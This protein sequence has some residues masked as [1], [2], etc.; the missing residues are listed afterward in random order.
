M[1]FIDFH[2]KASVEEQKW[3]TR[4][5]EGIDMG[6]KVSES[7]NPYFR[8]CSLPAL[9]LKDLPDLLDGAHFTQTL[10]GFSLFL[11]G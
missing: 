5:Q 3:K 9:C 7:S 10:Q 8:S 2:L 6:L 1:V 11:R 4:F